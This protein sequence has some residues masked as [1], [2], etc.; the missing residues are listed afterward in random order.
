MTSEKELKISYDELTRIIWKCPKCKAEQGLDISKEE[1]A[2]LL[3]DENRFF[4]CGMCSQQYDFKLFKA[5]QHLLNFY[6]TLEQSG[7]K[8]FFRISVKNKEEETK[9]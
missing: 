6:G 7:N 2:K 3:L 9:Q 8:V 4:R 5:F 1:Q